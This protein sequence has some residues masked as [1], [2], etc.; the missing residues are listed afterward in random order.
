MARTKKEK[1]IDWRDPNEFR[2]HLDTRITTGVNAYANTIRSPA[3]AGSMTFTTREMGLYLERHCLNGELYAYVQQAKG[4]IQAARDGA[5]KQLD[6]TR[7]SGSW[8][9][10][11]ESRM[12]TG[13]KIPVYFSGYS[14]DAA[15]ALIQFN[16][17][18]LIPALDFESH[19]DNFF[20]R[21]FGSYTASRAD[22]DALLDRYGLS[23]RRA[24]TPRPGAE[25]QVI[26]DAW[27]KWAI[28]FDE[29]HSKAVVARSFVSMIFTMS[30]TTLAAFRTFSGLRV[31]CE[32]FGME[33]ERMHAAQQPSRGARA[34][35]VD[36]ARLRS[37][38][39][40]W[41]FDWERH[42]EVLMAM[43]TAKRLH[44]N[45]TNHAATVVVIDETEEG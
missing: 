35:R 38:R 26:H 22:V 40:Q 39:P 36:T 7:M 24:L 27:I 9:E 6:G 33:P 21:Y 4:I 1:P 30:E 14:R 19:M 31:I 37:T 28:E 16:V 12:L 41:A 34:D 44:P 29:A 43:A 2:L 18:S 10:T 20:N 13:Q 5:A 45:A 23:T 25:S 11:L 32:A 3:A 42:R 8:H 15:S 17:Q